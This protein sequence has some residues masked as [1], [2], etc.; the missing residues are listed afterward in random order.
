MSYGRSPAWT[1]LLP[2]LKWAARK[3]LQLQPEFV[4]WQAHLN[5]S[6]N[7]FLCVVKVL[8][9]DQ[10]KRTSRKGHVQILARNRI[11]LL[12]KW[13]GIRGSHWEWPSFYS[14][15]PMAETADNGFE[16]ASSQRP[17]IYQKGSKLRN[18]VTSCFF[19]LLFHDTNSNYTCTR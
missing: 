18:V 9:D 8:V 4:L 6:C 11:L 13:S 16:D 15:Y 5:K 2:R 7:F 12:H 10:W 19:F 14:S 1:T 17:A 3:H